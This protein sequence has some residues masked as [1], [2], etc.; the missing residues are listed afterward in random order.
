MKI[1]VPVLQFFV[2]NPVMRED[3]PTERGC[4][5]VL[6]GVAMSKPFLRLGR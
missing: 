1:N 3:T 2:I 6:L 5:G 4:P